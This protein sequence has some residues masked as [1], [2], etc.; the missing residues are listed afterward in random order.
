MTSILKMLCATILEECSKAAQ[1]NEISRMIRMAI[2]EYCKHNNK[3]K[4]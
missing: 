3:T 4:T 1:F 2:H